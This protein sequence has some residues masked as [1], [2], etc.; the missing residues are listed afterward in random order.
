MKESNINLEKQKWLDVLKTDSTNLEALANLGKILYDQED[1]NEAIKYFNRALEIAPHDTWI[2]FHIALSFSNINDLEQ[3]IIHYKEFLA[4]EPENTNV[5]YNLA[6][7]YSGKQD[8]SK[9][10]ETYRTLLEI[11]P[12]DLSAWLN[13]GN[14]LD[15]QNKVDE[16]IDAYREAVVRDPTYIKAYYNLGLLLER[17]ERNKEAEKIYQEAFEN[18]PFSTIF[19]KKIYQF[20]GNQT[21]IPS[22]VAAS[23]KK[24][25]A[26]ENYSVTIIGD[27]QS[28]GTIK[29]KFILMLYEG[30]SLEP[31]YYLSLEENNLFLDLG[32]NQFFLCAFDKGN[33]LNFGGFEAEATI[34]NFTKVALEKIAF[35][36]NI[37]MDKMPS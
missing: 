24:Q 36:F 33:H 25:L 18:N 13:L 8:F 32:G 10:E 3:A 34:Y 37:P 30:D 31:S 7:M 6:L 26:I 20:T 11:K 35:R 19:L 29:Y 21:Y 2:L 28:A 14:V 22:I 23:L 4:I 27:I 15:A 1:F 16:A 17:I 5:W 12:T 9:A